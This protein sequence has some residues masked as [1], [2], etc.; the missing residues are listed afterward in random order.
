MISKFGTNGI[1][2]Y[3][4]FNQTVIRNTISGTNTS[5][6]GLLLTAGQFNKFYYN[7]I[8]GSNL[9]LELSQTFWNNVS[10][11]T[12]QNTF[13]NGTLISNSFYNTIGYNSFADSS[14]FF[15][16]IMSHGANNRVIGN[17][18]ND[19]WYYDLI[20]QGENNATVGRNAF[21]NPSHFDGSQALDS[22]VFNEFLYNYWDGWT[23]P[24]T[25]G[26]G[27]VDNPFPIDGP[28]HAFDFKPL[29][30]V[31]ETNLFPFATIPKSN[32]T[33]I[34][35]VTVGSSTNST[36]STNKPSPG[37]TTVALISGLLV[38]TVAALLRR[39]KIKS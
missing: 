34:V 37:F 18:F 21:L 3:D 9:W 33:V 16:L 26:D 10:Y 23:A 20:L 2:L 22:G 35:T 15:S 25:N 32:T 30:T 13:T 8:E 5:L 7:T 17:K 36:T 6:I 39:R 29:V 28:A 4:V 19:S 11:N 24:D 1:E 31:S 12:F 38:L 27:L 14:A